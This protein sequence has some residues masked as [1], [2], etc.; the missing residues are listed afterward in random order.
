M[1]GASVASVV[2]SV[3][4]VAVA[5]VAYKVRIVERQTNSRLTNM[6]AELS[7]MREERDEARRQLQE[8]DDA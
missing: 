5:Y 4:G 6:D 8:H 2:S 7:T 1:D 3:S